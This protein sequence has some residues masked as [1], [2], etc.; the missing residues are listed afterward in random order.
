MRKVINKYKVLFAI[1]RTHRNPFL[2]VLEHFKLL[3]KK[4]MIIR[5]K[6]GLKF[7]VRIRSDDTRIIR[8]IFVHNV[9]NNILSSNK[10]SNHGGTVGVDIGA[11][12]GLFSVLAAAKLKHVRIF[13]FEPLPENYRLLQ[14]NICINNLEGKVFPICK[15][16][17]V[18]AGESLI[19]RT[20]Y[21]NMS[22]ASMYLRNDHS[23]PG[24]KIKVETITL[25]DIFRICSISHIDFLKVDCEG[26]EYEIFYST[27]TEYLRKIS[28]M[29][30]EYHAHTCYSDW[31]NEK[32]KLKN[33]LCKLGFLVEEFINYIYAKQKH[34]Q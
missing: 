29:I 17:S 16:I 23:F 10:I 7:K 2:L 4:E 9:Y 33:F 32:E 30:I 5:M 24:T 8:E 13:S 31:Y 22:G 1:F 15:A 21:D 20:N 34:Y 6:N 25:S 18:K 14:E 27:P 19:L 3:K 26:C 11:H 28:E 12:I